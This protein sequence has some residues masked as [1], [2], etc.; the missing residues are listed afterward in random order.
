VLDYD[1]RAGIVAAAPRLE[2][3]VEKIRGIGDER[4]DLLGISSGGLIARYFL[5]YGGENVLGQSNP[6]PTGEGAERVRRVVYVGT[7]Q[8]GSLYA[9]E[10]LVGGVRPAP[11]GRRFEPKDLARFQTV[12]DCLPHPDEP[13]FVNERA[14]LLN[15]SLYDS[16]AW[17]RLHISPLSLPEV[18][19]RLNGARNLH[20]AFDRPFHHRDSIVIG[21]RNL[22]TSVRAVVVDGQVNLAPCVPEPNDPIGSALYQPGDNSVPE[23]SL[24]ALPGLDPKRVWWMTLKAHHL[25][26]SRPEIHRLI[27]EALLFSETPGQSLGVEAR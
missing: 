21:A 25:L 8:R 2:A 9:F 11:L 10:T 14:E 20:Q 6:A 23:A 1:W 16:G 18:T 17:E 5:A 7:G 27:L 15:E 26:P 12:W 3:L 24:R 19:E 22:P 4:V 13:G